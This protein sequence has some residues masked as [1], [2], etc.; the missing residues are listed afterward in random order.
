MGRGGGKRNAYEVLVARPDGRKL[1]ERPKSRREDN[2]EKDLEEIG[3]EGVEWVYQVQDKHDWLALVDN[4]I[5]LEFSSNVRSCTADNKLIFHKL[6]Y[7]VFH[8]TFITT[9]N[10]FVKSS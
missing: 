10:A 4:I 2:I 9:G 5:N 3:W 1:L 8:S 6:L 7:L